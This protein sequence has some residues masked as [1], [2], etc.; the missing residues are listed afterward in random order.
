METRA[1]DLPLT[2]AEGAPP[3]PAPTGAAPC[4]N[5]VD[6]FIT[7]CVLAY[8]GINVYGAIDV[9]AGYESHGVPLNK[10]AMSGVEDSIRKNSNRPMWTLVPGGLQQSNIGI[11]GK[12]P[13][14]PGLDFIFD[15]DFAFDPYTLTAANGP[16]SLLDNNGVPLAL[17]TSNGD[18]SRAGQFYNSVGYAGLSSNTLGDL[19]FGWQNSLEM[20]A[21]IAYDPVYA[22]CAFSVLGCQGFAI[23][24]GDAESAKYTSLKYRTNVGDFFWVAAQVQ[25]G[26]YDLGNSNQSAYG[27]Q[28]GK[29]FNLGAYGKLWFDALYSADKGAVAASPL[30]QAQNLLFPG[31][32]NASISDNNSWMLAA[33]YAYLNIQLFAGYEFITY[34][35]PVSPVTANFTGIA[36]IPITFAPGA[37][38]NNPV[39]QADFPHPE[40]L[41]IMWVGG[42]YSFTE[43]MDA[44]IAYYR[45]QQNSFGAVFC[46]TNVSPK[47]SGSLDAVGFDI[48][49]KAAK[50]LTLYAGFL[51]SEVHNGLAS[52]YLN[53]A[54]FS[55]TVGLR[56]RW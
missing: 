29:D 33:K 8:Y 51:Y 9:G 25:I 11:R 49:W 35:N 4:G 3:P 48:E 39:T 7:D 16:K 46:N 30:N 19:T 28:L 43:K 23:G 15:L 41:Q 1:A 21:V 36:G 2:Y 32:L 31:T 52:G 55:P 38:A 50:K 53:S 37:G 56:F 45:Y 12:E 5:A 34:A 24:G 26:G 47:C 20:D 27:F 10:D 6:F 18:G 17:Q 40:H 42:R 44:A 22:G 54:D 14:A 13:V